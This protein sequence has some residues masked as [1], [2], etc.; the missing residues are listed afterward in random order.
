MKSH[1]KPAA[2]EDYIIPTLNPVVA[3][4]DVVSN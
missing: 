3:T 1:F 4:A 2:S